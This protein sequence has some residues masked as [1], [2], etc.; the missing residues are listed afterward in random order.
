MGLEIINR[1]I[2]E[3]QQ[4][5]GIRPAWFDH[6]LQQLLAMKSKFE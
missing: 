6:A 1:L 2:G 3:I 5:G 4:K